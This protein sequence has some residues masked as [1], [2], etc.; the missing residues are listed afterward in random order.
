M[1]KKLLNKT[2]T[3][4]VTGQAGKS[5]GS[6]LLG[7][8][9]INYSKYF[10]I[11]ALFFL[12]SIL[13]S[14]R[15]VITRQTLY[16]DMFFVYSTLTF[17]TLTIK[18][19]GSTLHFTDRWAKYRPRKWPDIDIIIPAYNEGKAIYDTVYSITKANYPKDRINIVLV[20]DGSKDD[21]LKYIDLAVKDFANMKIVRINFK[22]NKGKKEAMA[23]GIRRIESDTIIFIDSDSSI[24]PNCLKEIVRPFSKDKKI[25]AVSG[26]ALVSNADANLL[27]KM[28]EI[29]YFNAFRSAKALESLLGFVSCCP[30]C[31]SAYK[32]EAILPIMKAWLNQSFLGVKCMYGDDRSLTN[33]VLKSRWKA[34]YNEKAVAY[35]IVPTTLKQYNKQQ[36][37]WK[38]SWLRES[39]VVL[40]FVWKRNPFTA[41]LMIAD[42]LTPFL[43]PII[44]ARIM[45]VY[46]VNNFNGFAYYMIGILIFAT[47]LGLLYRVHN[48]R[49][50]KWLKG[51][52]FSS[53][54]AI[55][56]FWQLPYALMTLRDSKWGTR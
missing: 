33:L 32:R 17:A 42:T 24:D 14:Y 51:A 48:N 7:E 52:L 31:C 16:F 5:F 54:I 23:E 1:K 56:T 29:R 44:I 36:I 18:Y 13:V 53:L 9:K 50:N 22:K 11:F 41:F 55:L 28:Q 2:N 25:G 21:T 35:T 40:S 12:F 20:N 15:V 37:R 27:A 43:A 3:L 4:I 46:S 34:V 19:L 6:Y 8:I 45:F 38:K 30:G 47:C 26:H 49:G 10:Y 39:V